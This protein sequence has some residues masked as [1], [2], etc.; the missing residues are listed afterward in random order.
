MTL[1]AQKII[2]IIAV[3]FTVVFGLEALA[4]ILNL[5]QV[6]IFLNL[7]FWLWLYLAVL[8]VFWYDLHFKNPGALARA[9]ARHESVPHWLN[10]AVKIWSSAFW[11]R[12]EHFRRWKYFQHWQNYL[13]LPGLAFWATV[14]MLYLN[15]GS[16]N[17]K[18]QQIFILLSGVALIFCYGY[19]K[20]IFRRR[21]DVVDNDA[22]VT[23]SVVKVYTAGMLYG[24]GMG[25][26]RRYCLSPWLFVGLIFSLTF[27]LV[28]Q[29]LFQHRLIRFSTLMITLAIAGAMSGVGYLVYRFWG[30]NFYTA[31]IFMAACY[32]LFWGTF[33]YHLDH[34]LTRRVFVEILA[35]SLLVG[36]MVLQVTNFKAEI[37]GACT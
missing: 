22:F 14:T 31:A 6:R 17:W 5:N 35:I 21:K 27:L 8:M 24:A 34:S 33:H 12:I 23:L 32:N 37:L 28:Y 7:S 13:L 26:M 1:R 16:W 25:L 2:S 15:I 11:E 18:I 3:S 19:L 36:F 30:Y 4:Y 29:A 20:E 10:R 9:R